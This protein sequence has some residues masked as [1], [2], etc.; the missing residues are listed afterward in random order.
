MQLFVHE[1]TPWATNDML[2]QGT[3]SPRTT[4]MIV[5]STAHPSCKPCKQSRAGNTCGA[6]WWQ[7]HHPSAI[8]LPCTTHHQPPILGSFTA[9]A[10]PQSNPVPLLQD[11]P[12]ATDTMLLFAATWCLS[13]SYTL[14]CCWHC[15]PL[16]SGSSPAAA[17]GAA[18]GIMAG[19]VP[20]VSCS[21]HACTPAFTT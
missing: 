9:T 20:K 3:I 7:H 13:C 4:I 11:T 6:W 12:S 8:T 10:P 2:F 18:P 1:A 21:R 19:P 14:D 17:D 15:W 16:P 5:E